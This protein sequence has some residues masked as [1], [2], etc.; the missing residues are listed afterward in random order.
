MAESEGNEKAFKTA[1]AEVHALDAPIDALSKKLFPSRKTERLTTTTGIFFGDEAPGGAEPVAATP[2][3]LV[4]AEAEPAL[5]PASTAV[6]R[7]LAVI[8]PFTSGA[9]AQAKPKTDRSAGTFM[10]DPRALGVDAKRFQFKSEVDQEGVNTTLRNVEKWRR[11]RGNQII[12]W[13][14]TAGQIFVVDGHQR[15]GLA[16]RLLAEGKET[17]I[18]VPGVLFR[19]ADGVTVEGVTRIA[20]LK[21][22][23]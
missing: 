21:N 17:D 3:P 23:T 4:P 18:Q 9:V 10:F 1:V 8:P 12:V 5:E 7:A 20:A 19:E 22:I 6:Q 11:E 15:I 16:K 14:D 13:Q 2:V